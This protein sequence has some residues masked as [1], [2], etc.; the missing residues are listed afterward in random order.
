MDAYQPQDR[1][2][3]TQQ[4]MQQYIQQVLA[5][6]DAVRKATGQQPI[7]RQDP[8]PFA[9]PTVTLPDPQGPGGQLPWSR[10]MEAPQGPTWEQEMARDYIAKMQG[11]IPD[12]RA[13]SAVYYPERELARQ[14][15]GLGGYVMPQGM[16]LE[17]R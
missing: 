11:R 14:L 1:S 17:G 9:G 3:I 16:S 5:Q 15:L 6:I 13:Q 12:A 8:P 7:P 2:A 10:S 4:A